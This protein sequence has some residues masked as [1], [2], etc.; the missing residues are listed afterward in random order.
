ME[1]DGNF[2][3]PL[4]FTS[5]EAVPS[6]IFPDFTLNLLDLFPAPPAED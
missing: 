5:E 3:R 6:V 2:G 4:I 1:E